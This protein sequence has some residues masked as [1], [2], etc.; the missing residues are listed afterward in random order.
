[1]ARLLL[2]IALV[3]VTVGLS[4][5]GGGSGGRATD[6]TTTAAPKACPKAWAADWQRL[7]NDVG[8][9]VYCPGWMPYPLDA[10]IDGTYRNGRWVDKKDKSYLVS[11]LWVD[12][13]AGI[14]REVHVNLRGYPGRTTVPT[15]ESVL[16]V[17]GKTVR[18]RMPC[19]TDVRER[20]TIGDIN[21]TVYSVNQGIDAWHVLYAW[22]KDGSLYTISE[23]V[24]APYTYKDVVR[25]L[26]R[27]ARRLVLVE[28]SA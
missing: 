20:R 5:C 17:Q 1:M 24:V 8:V 27:M 7:A 13:D 4:A 28:P 23:H 19:F 15:C 2:I 18:T 9:A 14:S 16:T 22:P 12:S 21:A 11:F 10:K 26:D 3:V 25:N 6:A